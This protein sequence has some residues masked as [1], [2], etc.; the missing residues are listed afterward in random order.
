MDLKGLEMRL[1]GSEEEKR[2]AIDA[3][4]EHY[5][6]KLAVY[7]GQIENIKKTIREYED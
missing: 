5:T 3:L 7:V 4:N 2:D 6:E 1:R